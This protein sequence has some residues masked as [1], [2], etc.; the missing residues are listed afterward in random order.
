LGFLDRFR[1]GGAA[2]DGPAPPVEA[3]AAGDPSALGIFAG[4]FV[5]SPEELASWDLDGL[6]PSAWPAV[7]FKSASGVELG[8]LEAILTGAPYDDIDQDDLHDLIRDGG[9]EGPWVGRVRPQLVTALADL[10]AD[11]IEAA[12]RSWADTDEFKMNPTDEPDI[13]TVADLSE[14]LTEFVQLAR[15][16]RQQGKPMYTMMSL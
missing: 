4:L 2:E 14:S 12:A 6:T 9:E 10:P 7:L 3:P 8:N 5:A 11:G 15:I 1:H 13:E 16:A